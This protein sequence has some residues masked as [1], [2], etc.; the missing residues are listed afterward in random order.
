LY[1]LC[2]NLASRQPLLLAVPALTP[3][4]RRVADHAAA[5]ATNPEVAQALF[6]TVKTVEMHLSNVFRKLD[7]TSRQELAGKLS[8]HT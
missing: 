2:A 1:W 5:G 3:S 7:I 6:V 4:E 8:A